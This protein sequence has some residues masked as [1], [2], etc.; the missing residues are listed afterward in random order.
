MVKC[1]FYYC[2]Y[3]GLV[4]VLYLDMI[5]INFKLQCHWGQNLISFL[6]FKSRNIHYR[7]IL[8]QTV[9]EKSNITLLTP[10]NCHAEPSL[11]K[12]PSVIENCFT[13]TFQYNF[14]DRYPWPVS[15]PPLTLS[16]TVSSL[17]ALYFSAHFESVPASQLHPGT[18]RPGTLGHHH[19]QCSDK[20]GIRCCW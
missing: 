11:I 20:C 6:F 4:S 10:F 8:G 17:H 9:F 3:H 15:P 16:T 19:R 13:S 18:S 7:S 1:K 12:G 5:P 2:S 14:V